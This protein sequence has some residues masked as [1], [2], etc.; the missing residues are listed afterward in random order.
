M[1]AMDRRDEW[2]L[3]LL[4][5]RGAEDYDTLAQSLGVSVMT[6]RRA[7]NR[8]AE[9]GLVIKTLGGAQLAEGASSGLYESDLASRLTEHREEKRALACA[10]R[11]QLRR[12]ETI[13]L[14]GSTTCLE[15][16]VVL[17]DV[18]PGYSFLTNSVVV[19]R[20]LGRSR[21]HAVTML[22]GQFDPASLCCVGPLCEEALNRMH[23]DKAVFSTK[24]FV[25]G[26]GTYESAA[27]LFR[28]KQ[29]AARR[30]DKV[31]LLAD[32]SK[33]GRRALCRALDMD[34]IDVVVTDRAT[35]VEALRVL[36]QAGKEVIVA[37][38]IGGGQKPE[39]IRSAER[40]A[41][42]HRL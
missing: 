6:V 35:P 33:F 27:P 40:R 34:D 3:D 37:D 32:H 14:D 10:M 17:R 1:S 41:G 7:V 36:E 26:E 5:V 24:G 8:L 42:V 19:G 11:A 38:G 31:F 16:A 9:R 29:M 13:F 23:F 12:G 39:I 4:R 20:E 2:L 28:I 30:S 21:Q 22:G 25:P 15:L 18:G